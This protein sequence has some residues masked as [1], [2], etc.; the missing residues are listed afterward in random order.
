MLFLSHIRITPPKPLNFAK[1]GLIIYPPLIYATTKTIAEMNE[2]ISKIREVLLSR[3]MFAELRGFNAGVRLFAENEG[4]KKSFWQR[5]KGKILAG[6]ALAGVGGLAYANRDNIQ[7]LAGKPYT[8]ADL[9]ALANKCNEAVDK[10]GDIESTESLKLSVQSVQ[11]LVSILDY[12]YLQNPDELAQAHRIKQLFE[13]M[14]SVIEKNKQ[15]ALDRWAGDPVRQNLMS[16]QFEL[17]HK[18]YVQLTNSKIRTSRI[19][20]TPVEK[21][22]DATIGRTAN[23]AQNTTGSAAPVQ[24]NTGY[25]YYG[26]KQGYQR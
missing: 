1:L 21:V 26:Y 23:N 10:T 8:V 2:K 9:A 24:G 22:L 18:A 25:G 7:R 20:N 14:L 16:K 4:K 11:E 5:H 19:D 12:G 15:K 3:R 6:M 13:S 17:L